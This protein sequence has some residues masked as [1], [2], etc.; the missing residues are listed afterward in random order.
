[1]DRVRV[2]LRHH[3]GI[4]ARWSCKIRQ[5]FL[6][7]G[8]PRGF[9]HILAIAHITFGAYGAAHMLLHE[10]AL[11]VVAVGVADA[12]VALLDLA[13]LVK[14]RVGDGLRC[15]REHSFCRCGGVHGVGFGGGA[16][17]GTGEHR[18]SAGA[19]GRHAAIAV[20]G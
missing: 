5:P 9:S 11:V 15:G 4:Y 18:L 13:H 6:R 12:V 16:I 7:C 19:L 8:I 14:P 10:D 2:V 20:V 3:Y 1:M 17:Y